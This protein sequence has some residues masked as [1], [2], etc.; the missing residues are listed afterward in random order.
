[1]GHEIGNVPW[2]V[3][4]LHRHGAENSVVEEIWFFGSWFGSGVYLFIYYTIRYDTIEEINV[5]ETMKTMKIVHEVGRQSKYNS[6]MQWDT[7]TTST[8]ELDVDY[9]N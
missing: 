8:Q 2:V 6:E 1:L 5:D 9:T 4:N 7:N 3:L